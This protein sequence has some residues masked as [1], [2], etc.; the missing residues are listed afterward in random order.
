MVFLIWSVV[1]FLVSIVAYASGGFTSILHPHESPTNNPSSLPAVIAYIIV[2]CAAF[3]AAAIA[4]A[5]F[6]F[7]RIWSRTL[8]FRDHNVMGWTIPKAHSEFQKPN[9]SRLKK[10]LLEFRGRRR[11]TPQ[12][13]HAGSTTSDPEKV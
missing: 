11:R 9:L 5:T 3:V 13:I 10:G 7:S 8:Y 1:A 2:V 12:D 6:V 4:F